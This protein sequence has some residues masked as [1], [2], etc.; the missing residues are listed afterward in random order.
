[1]AISFLYT[2]LQLEIDC[3]DCSQND[4]VSELTCK[5]NSMKLRCSSGLH[6]ASDLWMYF[7]NHQTNRTAYCRPN[8]QY[9]EFHR[10]WVLHRETP[11]YDC[12]LE[13][14]LCDY[15]DA[16]DYQCKVFIPNK[17]S[18][19]QSESRS[20]SVQSTSPQNEWQIEGGSVGIGVG[21]AVTIVLVALIAGGIVVMVVKRRGQVVPA[22][23]EDQNGKNNS[24]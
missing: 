8:Q 6:D 14:P 5:D 9:R 19:V 20:I 18:W 3:S 11:N 1:M 10:G 16:G 7:S 12:V 24:F 23:P 21:I 22:D 4:T 17:G 2:G 13:I 15:E